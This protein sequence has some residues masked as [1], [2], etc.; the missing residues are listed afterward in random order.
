MREV[1][2]WCCHVCMAWVCLLVV[3]HLYE[4]IQNWYMLTVLMFVQCYTDIT[5]LLGQFALSCLWCTTEQLSLLQNPY[6]HSSLLQLVLILNMMHLQFQSSTVAHASCIESYVV[7][8]Y[9]EISMKVSHLSLDV[10]FKLPYAV[11]AIMGIHCND[12]FLHCYKL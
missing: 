2:Q 6:G 11:L 3:I 7:I 12:I 9:N 1:W 5:P 10:I 8:C 4:Y